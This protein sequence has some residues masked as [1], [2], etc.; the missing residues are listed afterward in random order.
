M[1]L[2]K[3]TGKFSSLSDWLRQG[4]H[5]FWHLFIWRL[6]NPVY[7]AQV[8]ISIMTGRFPTPGF[9]SDLKWCIHLS[10]SK[11]LFAFQLLST[12]GE[13]SFQEYFPKAIS[14]PVFFSDLVYKL[15]M[16][17]GAVDFVSSDSKIVERFRHRKYDPV[18]IERTIGLVLG[19]STALYISFL[20]HYTLTYKAVGTIRALVFV[21]IDCLSG[22]LQPLALSSLPDGRSKAYSGGGLYMFL[23]YYI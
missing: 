3:E 13:I 10:S 17:K 5:R 1:G 6:S 16:V 21:P 4:M 2:L 14:H 19:L 18:I 15:R 11:S 23:T 7:L 8:C 12:F 9:E 22:L 20:E